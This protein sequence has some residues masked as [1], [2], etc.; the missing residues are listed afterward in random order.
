MT[1]KEAIKIIQTERNHCATHNQDKG[2]SEEYHK[3]MESLVNAFDLAIKALEET[4]GKT[5]DR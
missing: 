2:M 4:K 3:E 5:N 1:N